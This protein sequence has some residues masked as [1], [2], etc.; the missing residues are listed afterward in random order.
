MQSG[1]RDGLHTVAPQNA[2]THHALFAL[3]AMSNCIW[4]V[5]TSTNHEM[6]HKL[7][8]LEHIFYLL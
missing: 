7:E 6:N 3:L 4:H 1:Y 8:E 2:S 5:L